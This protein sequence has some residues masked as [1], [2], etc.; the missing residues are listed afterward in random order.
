MV[1]ASTLGIAVAPRVASADDFTSGQYCPTTCGGGLVCAPIIDSVVP[2]QP[3]ILAATKGD[4][5]L[6]RIPA[7]T[8]DVVSLVLKA[9]G[10]G[11]SHAALGWDAYHIANNTRAFDAANMASLP[12]VNRYSPPGTLQPGDVYL[13]PSWLANGLSTDGIQPIGSAGSLYNAG[14]AYDMFVAANPTTE[15]YTEQSANNLLGLG[16]GYGLYAYS[17]LWDDRFG[18]APYWYQTPLTH[19]G[20]MCSGS[21][22]LSTFGQPNSF[23]L[24]HYTAATRAQDANVI[25][26]MLTSN[27]ENEVQ[28]ALNAKL[29]IFSSFGPDAAWAIGM[30]IARQVV[31]CF[32]FGECGQNQYSQVDADNQ[33]AFQGGNWT[34]DPSIA[35]NPA[36]GVSL[37]NDGYTVGP[38]DLQNQVQAGTT[39]YSS[40]MTTQYVEP[41]G[42]DVNVTYGCTT[43]GTSPAWQLNGV[44]SINSLIGEEVAA[45]ESSGPHAEQTA[46]GATYEGCYADA[47]N[48]V[49]PAFLI[50]GGATVE[51]C[52]AAA[53]QAGYQYAGLQYYGQCF[54]GNT[55]GSGSP[56]EANCTTPCSSDSD[57]ICGGSW[58]NSVYH[59]Q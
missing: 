23:Q 13:D 29:G 19:G 20:G 44:T 10:Q 52:V 30:G 18:Y 38:I 31:H 40:I 16:I 3:R 26:E 1:L 32:A 58:N 37:M 11:H 22:Y 5:L 49:L 24:V 17:E 21:V 42:Y 43:P 48:R 8:T 4:L 47:P 53:R 56:N 33:G 55:L 36:N 2:F 57:E 50:G 27:I 34:G 25:Y 12:I 41:G 6:K 54:A 51:S 35:A 7:G 45:I 39:N 59:V 15:T 14:D 28:S 9:M 46:S